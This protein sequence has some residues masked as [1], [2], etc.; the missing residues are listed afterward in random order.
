MPVKL[1]TVN[2]CEAAAPTPTVRHHENRQEEEHVG[3]SRS[4]NNCQSA[5]ETK[6]GQASD[7]KSKKQRR[8]LAAR[9][10]RVANINTKS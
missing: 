7:Q 6:A 8:K 5:T 1:I 2:T 10:E 3:R 9:V 4:K